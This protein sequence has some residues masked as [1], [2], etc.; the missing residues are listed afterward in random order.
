MLLLSAKPC[1]I[2]IKCAIVLFY[3]AFYIE[4]SLRHPSLEN[5]FVYLSQH[6]RLFCEQRAMS[7]DEAFSDPDDVDVMLLEAEKIQSGRLKK[8]SK[9]TYASGL[10]QIT[11]FVRVNHPANFSTFTNEVI[12]P[13]PTDVML[14]FFAKSMKAP[15]GGYKSSSTING[16]RS[17]LKDLY[18]SK[19]M[20]MGEED[21]I[22]INDFIKGYRRLIA[23]EKEDGKMSIHEGKRPLPVQGYRLLCWSSLAYLSSTER[24]HVKLFSNYAHLYL[25]LQWNLMARTVSIS[26]IKYHHICWDGDCLT[27]VLPRHK[28]DQEGKNAS[29]KHVYAN[30]LE[31]QLCPVLALAIHMFCGG[32]HD[33]DYQNVFHGSSVESKFGTWLDKIL[34]NLDEQQ[35]MTL[36]LPVKDVGTHSIR[37]GIATFLT[38]VPGGP[39]IISIFLRLGWSLGTVVSRY[40]FDGD[41]GNDQLLGRLACLLPFT[42]TRFATLPPHFIRHTVTDEQWLSILPHYHS[43]PTSFRTAIPYLLA[44]IVYHKDWLRANLHADHPLFLSRVFTQ[45][46]VRELHPYVVCGEFMCGNTGMMATGLPT[47]L[48]LTCKLDQVVTRIDGLEKQAL[49]KL[50]KMEDTVPDAV[51]SKILSQLEVNGAVTVSRLDFERMFQE[52][53]GEM[54]NWRSSSAPAVQQPVVAANSLLRYETWTWGSRM[55]P[56][57]ESFH[58]PR[59]S[60]KVLWDLWYD[61]DTSLK[62]APYKQFHCWDMPTNK[63]KQ[64]LS[65]AKKIM[66]KLVDIANSMELIQTTS[67]ISSM[68]VAERDELFSRVFTG[69]LGQAENATKTVRDDIM[70]TTFYNV[71]QRELGK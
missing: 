38:S 64:S 56:V 11:D 67:E 4:N 14:R 19:K 10:G 58:F 63:D 44:S 30:P 17:A 61:G 31:P 33:N 23:Q 3:Q 69:L 47:H 46:H 20:V 21:V 71:I 9:K 12:L 18:H 45:G 66:N 13:L 65:K 40:I 32:F 24:N 35:L 53:R 42:D 39:S 60:V 57:P 8:S 50:D 16:Y 62:I 15:G 29:P 52:F 28:G 5:G 6:H 54:A 1:N 49:A 7:D 43:Y 37:K 68:S 51:V 41:G 55:H 26:T 36:G 2:I 59:C 25:L 22:A 34:G 48:S 70:Y 27:V